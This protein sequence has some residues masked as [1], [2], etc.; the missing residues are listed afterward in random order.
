MKR[1]VKCLLIFP[2]LFICAFQCES[3]DRAS[4]NLVNCTDQTVLIQSYTWPYQNRASEPY[5][6]APAESYELRRT[7]STGAAEDLVNIFGRNGI[8]L[9]TED[10]VLLRNWLHL[11]GEGSHV[12]ITEAIEKCYTFM[13]VSY[14]VRQFHDPDQWMRAKRKGI[15]EWTFN[16]LPEDLIPLSEFVRNKDK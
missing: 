7:S 5:R 16:I 2:P 14:G 11:D 8:L 9:S 3:D 6:I 1:F 12:A 13:F 15:D 10:G 4:F